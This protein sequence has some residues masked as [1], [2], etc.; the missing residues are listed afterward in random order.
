MTIRI[1]PEY[2][3]KERLW[4]VIR[5]ARQII[6]V[7]VVIGTVMI[8][9]APSFTGW[10]V[11]HEKANL[12][13][14]GEPTTLEEVIPRVPVGKPNAA[15]L[16]QKA[17]YLLRET[18]EDYDS[19]IEPQWSVKDKKWLL[20]ARAFVAKNADALLLIEKASRIPDCAFKVDWGGDPETMPRPPHY[21]YLRSAV[22]ILAVRGVVLAADGRADEALA[23]CATA[24]R[25]A[26]HIKID[27]G[28]LS[29]LFSHAL[30]NIAMRSLEAVLSS[31]DPSPKACQ[32][33]IS[34]LNA[35]DPRKSLIWGLRSERVLSE[36]TA[37]SAARKAVLVTYG[38]VSYLAGAVANV[39]D[40]LY[41]RDIQREIDAARLP[42]VDAARKGNEIM[43]DTEHRPLIVGLMS[44]F[45]MPFIVDM[46]EI[47]WRAAA[48]LYACQTALAVKVYYYEHGTFPK[49]LEE[50]GRVGLHSTADP[51]SGRQFRYKVTSNG[52][53]VWSVGPDMDDDGGRKLD[54]KTLKG[55]SEAEYQRRHWDYDV[56]FQVG[57]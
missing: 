6:S 7:L 45:T 35:V 42:W 1:Q 8:L 20:R 47:H 9:A 23:S 13:S 30:Q 43:S 53:V 2:A 29:Q 55:I 33:L 51:F 16:Y 31:S 36:R 40:L 21:N 56:P 18:S 4:R 24:L 11:D 37:L 34:Q 26:D 50:L 25:I 38:W 39:N 15:D 19:V 22:R 49:S 41:L 3:R 5:R 46:I 27:P 12:R 52:F 14:R 32:A 44:N 57:E 17:S 54:R 10:L 48:Q 28:T